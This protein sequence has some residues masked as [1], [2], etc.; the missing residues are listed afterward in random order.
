MAAEY[1]HK[2][3]V[4]H[5]ETWA[6]IQGRF[7]SMRR[8]LSENNKRQAMLP[9][10]CGV[11]KN[12][13]GSAAGVYIEQDGKTLILLPGPPNELE[14][15]FLHQAVPFLRK[16]AGG[17]FVSR[18]LKTTGI[19]ESMMETKIK[20]LIE[21]QSNPTIAPYAKLGEAWVRLTASAPDE[22]QAYAL[23]APVAEEIYR[24]LGE[25]IY[26]E[27][28][29]TPASVIVKT[30]ASK[31]LTI[32]CAESC[33]GGLLSSALV[34]IPGSSAVFLEG[35]VTY[36]NH[37]KVKRLG[38]PESIVDTYGAVSPQTAAAMAQGVAESSGTKVGLSTTGIA[39]PDGGTADK[40]VGLVYLGLYIE[41]KGVVTRELRL[42]GDRNAIRRRSVVNALDFLRL[43]II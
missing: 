35:A 20:D 9:K 32:A 2:P 34:D 18:A 24:R 25:F 33:T 23:I 27:D 39:G 11:L 37:A 7:S 1:F 31:G 14:P 22:E 36:C 29:D 21:S 26:G 10:G 40:P 13:H 3:L 41:G 43:H 30:L 28:D 6:R 38:V 5:E 17:V 15:M 8:S 12:D 4:F 16:K 42:K 19:G